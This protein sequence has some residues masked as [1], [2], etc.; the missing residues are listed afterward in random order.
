MVER[1]QADAT[2][3]VGHEGAAFGLDVLLGG[4]AMIARIS[5][6]AGAV[7]VRDRGL[8]LGLCFGSVSPRRLLRL[9]AAGDRCQ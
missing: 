6:P 5:R 3:E 9:I 1:V 7:N 4:H 2:D 8:C